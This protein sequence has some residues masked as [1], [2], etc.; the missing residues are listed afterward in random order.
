MSPVEVDLLGPLV[1][2]GDGLI[3]REL[4]TKLATVLMDFGF[5]LVASVLLCN[6]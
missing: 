6:L 5:Y 3:D 2:V 4:N 1:K